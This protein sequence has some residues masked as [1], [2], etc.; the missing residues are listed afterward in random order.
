MGKKGAATK[1]LIKNVSRNLFSSKGYKDVSMQDICNATGLSKGGLYRYFKS[2]GEILLQLVAEEKQITVL[3][4]IEN[5]LPATEV[6]DHLLDEY[7]KNMHLSNTS[8]AFALYEYA[9]SEEDISSEKQYLDGNNTSESAIWKSLVLYGIKSGVFHDI[10]YH[11]PMNSFLYAYR[12]VRMWSRV[13]EID[14][15]IYD[16]IIQSV[17]YLLIKDFA[18][19]INV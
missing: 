12:G 18:E 6:L 16:N 3:Q 2:K 14:N 7:K 19:D 17:K 5:G 13:L 10:D 1:E 15:A 4:D 8:L 9:A 11:I